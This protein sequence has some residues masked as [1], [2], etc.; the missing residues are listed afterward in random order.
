[1]E[2]SLVKCQLS[3]AKT[4]RVGLLGLFTSLL[5]SIFPSLSL[6]KQST[7][8]KCVK[9]AITTYLYHGGNFDLRFDFSQMKFGLTGDE[10]AQHYVTIVAFWK[11]LETNCLAKVS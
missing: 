11:V 5:I 6:F 2:S 7:T 9:E 3:P 10:Y 8:F 4:Q 1:M